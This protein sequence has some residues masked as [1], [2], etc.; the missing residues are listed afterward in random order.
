MSSKYHAERCGI[1][2]LVTHFCAIT[3]LPMPC[4]N[5]TFQFPTFILKIQSGPDVFRIKELAVLNT[6]PHWRDITDLVCK[7]CQ[8][9]FFWPIGTALEDTGPC[10][11]CLCKE[12]R[13]LDSSVF[14]Y[15]LP[16]FLVRERKCYI[17]GPLCPSSWDIFVLNV[18]CCLQVKMN[19]L[20]SG[21]QMHCIGGLLTLLSSNRQLT[22]L[23][24]F[25]KRIRVSWAEKGKGC[26]PCI[27]SVWFIH[28][29]CFTSR[30]TSISCYN[31]VDG[32]RLIT[33]M[34][35]A[36]LKHSLFMLLLFHAFRLLIW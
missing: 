25:D 16:P 36:C 28:W 6:F 29:I 33:R 20:I 10:P 8:H 26:F 5:A 12:D 17:I 30:D 3:L 34:L 9:I 13:F 24:C 31:F 2:S 27:H 19:N 35:V 4:L 18:Q 7:L 23:L 14:G 32:W 1:S 15:V 21:I 11:K 22:V